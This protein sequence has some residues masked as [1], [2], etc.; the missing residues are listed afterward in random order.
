MSKRNIPDFSHPTRVLR[1]YIQDRHGD[2]NIRVVRRGIYT[3]IAIDRHMPSRGP[4]RE[5]VHYRLRASSLHLGS[6]ALHLSTCIIKTEGGPE[7]KKNTRGKKAMSALHVADPI[8][9]NV[10]EIQMQFRRTG[11]TPADVHKYFGRVDDFLSR[12][13]PANRELAL[14][15]GR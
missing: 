6:E 15:R 7:K 5:R 3:K 8:Y 4:D 2:I 12:V 11:I 1:A 14:S 13:T 9:R 10:D